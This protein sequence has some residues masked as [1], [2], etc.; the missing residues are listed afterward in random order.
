LHRPEHPYHL[1]LEGDTNGGESEFYDLLEPFGQ[2]LSAST[3][4]GTVVV[5]V[6][7]SPD[8][9]DQVLSLETLLEGLP[10]AVVLPSYDP[11]L[12]GR[13]H[14]LRPRFLTY[15]DQEPEVLLAVL[16][17]IARKHWPGMVPY[18]PQ[19]SGPAQGAVGKR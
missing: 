8:Q 5:M 16:A 13:A 12:V 3:R 10:V 15:L 9:M 14:R 17:N 19:Q 1:L 2:R 11:V 7:D 6:L 18:P 4:D